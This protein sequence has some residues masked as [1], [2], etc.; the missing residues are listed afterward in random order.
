[1]N[2]I[3]IT[4]KAEL[5]G[6]PIDAAFLSKEQK[7]ISGID[8]TTK[9]FTVSEKTL[10][11]Y[12]KPDNPVNQTLT[13]VLSKLTFSSVDV[14]T[15]KKKLPEAIAQ[16]LDGI[17]VAINQVYFKSKT[18]DL[19]NEPD[20]VKIADVKEKNLKKNYELKNKEY[21]LWIDFEV[22]PE[23]MKGFPVEVK[24]LS[25]KIWS[26]NNTKVLEEMKITEIQKLLDGAGINTE[27]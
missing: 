27:S 8:D 13:A 4:A 17:T 19:F 1:M 12:G 18:V 11:V 20:N 14:A 16:T 10:V 5:F 24:T 22:D 2:N 9:K 6:A 21:A 7:N 26:T 23:L 15:L 3:Q 25:L